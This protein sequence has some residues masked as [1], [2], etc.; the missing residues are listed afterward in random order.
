MK[1]RATVCK[2]GHPLAGPTVWIGVQVKFCKRLGRLVPYAKRV[3]RLCRLR[4]DV[5]TRNGSQLPLL[6]ATTNGC[7]AS[8]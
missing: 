1:P 2:H 8:G 7:K 6:N 3:C 5:D 4:G